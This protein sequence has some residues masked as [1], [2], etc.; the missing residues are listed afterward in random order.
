MSTPHEFGPEDNRVF[1]DL[2]ARMLSVGTATTVF[3]VGA[4]VVAAMQISAGTKLAGPI[5][6]A[7]SATFL[8]AT[9][10]WSRR[11][12]REFRLVAATQGSDHTHLMAALGNLR[13]LYTFHHYLALAFLAVLALV[14]IFGLLAPTA[15]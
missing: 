10:V 9:G 15:R 2:A 11:A 13:R 12:G 4:L 1:G 5:A 8:I 7:L 3:G 14:I 6:L